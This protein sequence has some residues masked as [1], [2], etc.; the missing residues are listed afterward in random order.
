MIKYEIRGTTIRAKLINRIGDCTDYVWFWQLYNEL[1]RLNDDFLD[2]TIIENLIRKHVDRLTKYYADAKCDPTDAFNE[3][4][5]KNLAKKRLLKKFNKVR[6]NIMLEYW[7]LLAYNRQ[8]QDVCHRLAIIKNK[9][10]M[11]NNESE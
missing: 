9:E 6:Y 5:G 8:R 2:D 7:K 11:Y 10:R 3:E 1:G 4:Y